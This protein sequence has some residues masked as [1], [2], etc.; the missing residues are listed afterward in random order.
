[1]EI[2]RYIEV[3]KKGLTVSEQAVKA[4]CTAVIE[5]M[6]KEAQVISIEPPV[7]VCGDIH[8]ANYTT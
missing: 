6:A 3:L 1:M 4:I 8:I 5:I 7:S 2:E